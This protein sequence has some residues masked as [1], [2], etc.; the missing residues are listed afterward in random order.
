MSYHPLQSWPRVYIFCCQMS[1]HLPCVCDRRGHCQWPC[2]TLQEDRN[3]EVCGVEISC[4]QHHLE[5]IQVF[6][7]TISLSSKAILMALLNS[8]WNNPISTSSMYGWKRDYTWIHPL[9]K[10]VDTTRSPILYVSRRTASSSVSILHITVHCS[11]FFCH[12]PSHY[13]A[14]LCFWIRD[15]VPLYDV[16][17][18]L[19]SAMSHFFDIRVDSKFATIYRS[20]NKNIFKTSPTKYASPV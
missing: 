17:M 10:S 6:L 15:L 20:V 19:F 9:T 1:I 4:Y 2:M 14:I 16:W 18:I 12:L 7:H 3:V 5:C 11:N 13:G 8:V